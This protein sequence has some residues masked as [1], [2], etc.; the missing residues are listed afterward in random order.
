[1]T[2]KLIC[3][4]TQSVRTVGKHLFTQVAAVFLLAKKKKMYNYNTQRYITRNLLATHP[5][6]INKDGSF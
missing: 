3:L 5:T 2:R 4:L 6:R 1:M